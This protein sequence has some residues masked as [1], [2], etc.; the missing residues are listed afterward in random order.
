[1]FFNFSHFS[2]FAFFMS[3]HPLREITQIIIDNHFFSIFSLLEHHNTNIYCN[4]AVGSGRNPDKTMHRY[5]FAFSQEA[6][7]T[8]L[9]IIRHE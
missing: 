5:Y 1:M 7:Q 2:Y 4:F 6:S 8:I 3:G 9:G